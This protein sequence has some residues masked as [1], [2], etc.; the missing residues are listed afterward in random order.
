[1]TVFSANACLQEEQPAAVFTIKAT[2]VGD[3]HM[4]TP[5]KCFAC[6]WCWANTSA[7][8]FLYPSFTPPQWQFFYLHRMSVF[9]PQKFAFSSTIPMPEYS[10]AVHLSFADTICSSCPSPGE[11]KAWW[12]QQHRCSTSGKERQGSQLAYG[13]AG[14][15]PWIHYQKEKQL[16]LNVIYSQY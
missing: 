2:K 4:W 9:L 6:I 12:I 16:L 1:M 14:H 13:A 10:K 8:F 15:F 7:S 11:A 5:S 3:S